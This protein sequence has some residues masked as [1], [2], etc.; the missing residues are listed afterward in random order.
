[1]IERSDLVQAYG[2]RAMQKIASELGLEKFSERNK[3][4]L[5][6][7]HSE[8]TPSF[9]FDEKTF[10]WHCFGCGAN[11]DIVS[12]T[13]EYN[14]Y[15]YVQAVKEI[16]DEIGLNPQ[17]EHSDNSQVVR[18]DA[19]NYSRP[20][21]K[22]LELTDKML[23]YLEK[24][25]LKKSTLDFWRVG[26]VDNKSFKKGDEWVNRTAFT[27]KCFDEYN[28]LV[29]IAY[30]SGDKLFAQ[31]KD[32]KLIMYGAW[33]VDSTKPL[34]ITEGQF[35]AMAIW[36]SGITN[37]VSLPAG[38]ANRK[39]I[40][41]NYEFLNQFPE[42]IFWVDNDEPGRKAAS[43]L[44]ER[45]PETIVKIHKEFNDPNE[46][47]V[48]LGEKEIV[49]FL[50]ELPP[51]PNG[52]KGISDVSYNTGEV[53]D[54]ERIETGFADFDKFIKDW[55]MQQLTV[56]FGRDNEGKSTWISQLVAHQMKKGMKTFLD[57]AELG[58]QGIQDWLYKQII[59]GESNCYTKESGKYDD[60]YSIKPPVLEAIRRYTKD[61]LYIIDSSDTGIISDNDLLFK[62]LA[63]M[64]TK[65]GVKLFILDNLQAILTSKY[66]DINRDQS[67]FM[68]RCRQFAKTYNC[69]VIVV[70]H[71]HKVEELIGSE[72]TK[73]GNL[74]KDSISGTK[75]IS[76]KAHNIVSIER[77]FNDDRPFDMILTNLKNK[78]N[79]I[80]VG[81]KYFFDPTTFTFYNDD[82][83]QTDNN[84]TWKKYLSDDVDKNTLDRI[85]I[86][87]GPWEE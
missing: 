11:V 75:D 57:S 31:E 3:K 55:R 40:E 24:R 33:H 43:N 58:D 1:M 80:R 9:T 53:S 41:V 35:D 14:N 62:Q 7:F 12:H 5:C 59:N 83:I 64:A 48:N 27:F 67:F 20:N 18:E 2:D 77:P 85:V 68:E 42:L 46:T 19:K 16:C 61:K 51:L 52:V 87:R 15:S 32:C 4:A 8:K 86:T 39:Y 47:L 79:S 60:V 30:R 66:A 44:K 13:I 50:N 45:F 65:F 76:N 17:I 74:K 49:R 69:H 84:T 25:K 54:D 82:T 23:N 63:K 28:E 71:P 29:N 22:T 21:V 6:P 78:V 81:F 36:Q 72:T 56:V 37:V 38:A 26:R 10:T 73:T 34:Y 70:A